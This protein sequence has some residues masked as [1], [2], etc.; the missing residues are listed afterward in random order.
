MEHFMHRVKARQTVRVVS[1][2]FLMVFLGLVQ[3]QTKTDFSGTWKVNTS[4]SD[5]GPMPPPD[6]RV[7]KVTQ[8]DPD[9]KVNVASTG[10]PMGD[11]TYDVSYNTE[12]KETT[13]TVAGNEIKSTAKWD[14]AELA[15]ESKGSFNGTDFTSKERWGLSSDGKEL[16]KASHISSAMGEMD[17]KLVYEKQ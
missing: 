12:G 10:G 14:G 7:E 11:M 6:S 13:N 4:K 2:V 1:C 15:I 5:F 3:A 17:V 9:L 16:T 8:Q